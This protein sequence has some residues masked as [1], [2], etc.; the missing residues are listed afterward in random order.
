MQ[1]PD[2]D[3]EHRSTVEMPDELWSYTIE[4]LNMILTGETGPHYELVFGGTQLREAL[5]SIERQVYA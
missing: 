1:L 2:A 3:G 4:A 5:A